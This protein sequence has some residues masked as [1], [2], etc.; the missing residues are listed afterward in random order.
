MLWYLFMLLSALFALYLRL[1]FTWGVLSAVLAGVGCFLGLNAVF[2]LY[3]FTVSL[4][5]V[6]RE[7]VEKPNEYLRHLAYITMDWILAL[8]RIRVKGRNLERL[9]REPAVIISNHLSRFDPMALYC[10][11]RKRRL[12]F[13]SKIENMRIP[14]AG[15]VL[16]QIGF[17]PLERDNPLQAM[18]TI[19]T[20]AKMTR[21]NGFS[22]GIYPEGTRNTTDELLPFKPG[23]FVMAQ[24]AKAPL[25]VTIIRGTRGASGRLFTRASIEVLDVIPAE[26]VAAKKPEE[27][28]QE[29]E[30]I[31]RAAM[32]KEAAF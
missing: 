18:R 29:T 10:L 32:A 24:K 7:P 13:V 6:N 23:A 25:A 4:F 19:R 15:P 26:T 9:P 2:V 11:E 17:L 21:E 28:A 30:E 8:F 1:Q 3:L 16:Y 5:C 14:V 22:M 12:A 31:M 27:L 20:G